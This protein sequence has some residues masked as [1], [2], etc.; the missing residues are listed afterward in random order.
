MSKS[1]GTIRVGGGVGITGLL[2]VAFVVL[3]LCDVIDW[4]W[5]WVLSPA[6]LPL[7]FVLLIFVLVGVGWGIW[8][9]VDSFSNDSGDQP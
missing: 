4:S 7:T 1:R 5:L 2:L 8:S 3:K 9:L 6:W